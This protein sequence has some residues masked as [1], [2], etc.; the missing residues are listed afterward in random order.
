MVAITED[1]WW[2][3][4]GSGLAIVGC[5]FQA[6]GFIMQKI[7]HNNIEHFNNRITRRLSQINSP[8]SKNHQ[9]TCYDAD[10]DMFTEDDATES[11]KASVE[12]QTPQK[13]K[14]VGLRRSLS[15]HTRA[16][17]K[18]TYLQSRIWL[19]GFFLNGIVGSLLNIIA[20]NYAPQSVVLPLS[21]TTLVGNTVLATQYLG[22][23]FP[24]QDFVGV[25]L[26][27]LGLLISIHCAL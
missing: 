7:G 4:F 22:E 25:V 2:T 15:P 26:V 5:L 16:L 27:I 20:L 14:H 21:A 1:T 13:G 19:L 23:P 12:L 6:V 8:Q 24:V 10:L 17:K 18:K 3:I 11:L 9:T